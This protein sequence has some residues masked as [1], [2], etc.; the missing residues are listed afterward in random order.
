MGGGGPAPVVVGVD[1]RPVRHTVEWAAAEAAARGRPLRLVHA[2]PPPTDPGSVAHGGG[3]GLGAR[4]DGG[5]LREAVGWA[6]AVA[7]ELEVTTRVVA[8]GP[9]AALASQDADLLV[10]GHRGVGRSRGAPAGSIGIAV[11]ARAAGPVAVVPPD[12]DAGPGRSRARVVVGVDAP[13]RSAPAIGFAFRAA[14][15]RGTGLTALH[16]WTPRPPA[17]FSGITDDRAVA[18]VVA[19]RA[20]ADAL[21]PWRARYPGVDTRAELVRD[22]P[23]RALVAESAG[24]ALLVVGSRGRGALTGILF[25]S[26][27]HAALRGAHCPVAVV[28]SAARRR[29]PISATIRSRS[30]G[31]GNPQSGR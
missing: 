28:R 10:V 2:C 11:C 13:D 21:A 19:G 29:H 27:S 7:P 23:A 9:V 17:D 24:A 5:I 1:A 12:R 25:G 26:V 31:E 14:A 4:D 18:G 3:L 22:D 8:G 16:A 6:R 30:D 15:Q 20:L